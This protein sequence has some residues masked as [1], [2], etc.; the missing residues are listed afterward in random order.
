MA[1]SGEIKKQY[2]LQVAPVGSVDNLGTLHT[3][4][5]VGSILGTAIPSGIFPH[6]VPDSEKRP[7]RGYT[8]I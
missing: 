4:E 7:Y 6:T 5:A 8:R 1:S 3:V 2:D